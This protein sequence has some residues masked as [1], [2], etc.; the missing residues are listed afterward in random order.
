MTITV[1][2]DTLAFLGGALW[3]LA[4]GILWACTLATW[5]VVKENGR[6]KRTPTLDDDWGG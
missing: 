3:T 4:F 1:E 6:R 2:P 5:V